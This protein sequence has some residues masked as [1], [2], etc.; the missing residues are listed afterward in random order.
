MRGAITGRDVLLNSVSIVR[1]WGVAT[2]L[3]CCWAVFRRRGTFLDVLYR[4][5]RRTCQPAHR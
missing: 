1:L 4:G 2:Y 3:H 5:Q